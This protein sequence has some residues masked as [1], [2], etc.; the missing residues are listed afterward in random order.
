MNPHA[1]ISIVAGIDRELPNTRWMLDERV[2]P[3]AGDERIVFYRGDGPKWNFVIA[4]SEAALGYKVYDGAAMHRTEG[5]VVH[6]TPELA[7]KAADMAE[8]ETG[9]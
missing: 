7:K 8:K 4:V 9:R 6:L 2:S 3:P 1:L 5:V